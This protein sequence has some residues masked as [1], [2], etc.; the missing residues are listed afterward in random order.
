MSDPFAESTRTLMITAL[1]CVARDALLAY[2]RATADMGCGQTLARYISPAA[3]R[4]ALK[5]NETMDRLAAIDPT[6]PDYR[7]EGV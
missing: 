7:I 5:F 3:T 1:K 2:D 4:A 6:T